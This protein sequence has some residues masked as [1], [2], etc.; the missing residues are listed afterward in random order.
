[1]Y[2]Y[3]GHLCGPTYLSVWGTIWP[4][5]Y[6]WA[7]N[8]CFTAFILITYLWGREVLLP[9]FTDWETKTQ[10]GWVTFPRTH[11]KSVTEK[12]LEH[13]AL[14]SRLFG[15]APAHIFKGKE[16]SD[17]F[18]ELW[19]PKPIVLPHPNEQMLAWHLNVSEH[20]YIIWRQQMK[21]I[22]ISMSYSL[23]YS[24]FIFTH[25]SYKCKEHGEQEKVSL[26]H[27]CLI[28]C[29]SWDSL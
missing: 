22:K 10:R 20:Y 26:A 29:F 3:H 8:N 28:N 19:L 24:G 6:I 25:H 17:Y 21:N 23:V 5:L 4:I 1:M 18:T 15:G 11:R 27:S 13:W 16:L 2:I 7:S 9:P 12:R 14:R